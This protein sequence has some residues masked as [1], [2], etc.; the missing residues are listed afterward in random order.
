MSEEFFCCFILIVVVF[1]IKKIRLEMQR[2]SQA[3]SQSTHIFHNPKAVEPTLHKFSLPTTG[4]SRIYLPN[5]LKFYDSTENNT[6]TFSRS[7]S[8]SASDNAS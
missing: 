4:L 7:F 1:V 5:L 3:V 6:R 8:L 2:S